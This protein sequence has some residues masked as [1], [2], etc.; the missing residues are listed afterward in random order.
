MHAAPVVLLIEDSL[1]VQ[2]IVMTVLERVGIHV[3]PFQDAESGIAVLEAEEITIDVV[4]TDLQLP[5]ASGQSVV[6]WVRGSQ[7]TIG[8]VIV[9]GDV[10][11][12]AEEIAETSERIVFLNKPFAPSELIEAVRNVAT[13][14]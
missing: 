12:E 9:S 8:L 6:D 1:P 11:S 5:G 3:H 14:P 13:V 2:R 4:I 10:Q 7:R